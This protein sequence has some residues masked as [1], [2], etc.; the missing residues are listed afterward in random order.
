[1]QGQ[2]RPFCVD[3]SLFLLVSKDKA[4]LKGIL[5][6]KKQ[7]I[8]SRDICASCNLWNDGVKLM[9]LHIA[10]RSGPEFGAED[11]FV[12][13][14]LPQFQF[15]LFHKGRE[16]CAC[17]RSAGRAVDLS[18]PKHDHVLNIRVRCLG[19]PIYF[20]E[21]DAFDRYFRMTHHDLFIDAFT[22]LQRSGHNYRELIGRDL[23]DP[24]FYLE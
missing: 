4:G 2:K 8:E 11:T 20:N 3:Q 21:I 19:R 12:N 16:L 1:M 17:A 7:R 18:M 9:D 23:L 10:Q 22:Q 14:L 5:L 6:V 24:Q 15:S 13:K